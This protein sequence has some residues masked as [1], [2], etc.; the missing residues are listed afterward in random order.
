M[1]VAPASRRRRPERGRS[2]APVSTAPRARACHLLHRVRR[3]RDAPLVRVDLLGDADLHG[4]AGYTGG[5]QHRHIAVAASTGFLAFGFLAAHDRQ[6]DP[7]L[8]R[9]RL[10]V[11]GDLTLPLWYQPNDPVENSRLSAT[12]SELPMTIF[13]AS[14]FS[15]NSV[16]E[17]GHGDFAM[18]RTVSQT[19][20]CLACRNP[21]RRASPS[22]AAQEPAAP[23]ETRPQNRQR[24]GTDRSAPTATTPIA[25]RLRT[26]PTATGSQMK[27]ERPC[28][29]TSPRACQ[30]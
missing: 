19:P 23:G 12:S 9:Q 4:P 28:L 17:T 18:A 2:P 10:A 30:I 15:R 27:G 22:M 20:L 29:E 26:P 13:T 7:A 14:A 11:D 1:I 21:T 5:G 8:H 16:F 25:P 3:R 24:S 6:V